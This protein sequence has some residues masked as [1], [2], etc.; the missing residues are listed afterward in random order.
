VQ[1]VES[2]RWQVIPY[3]PAYEVSDRGDVRR[4]T[5][6]SGTHK[7]LV[8]RGSVSR[9]GRRH[10]TLREGGRNVD[11]PVH[12]LVA[13]AFVPGRFP[14]AVVNHIDGNPLNNAATN[15]EWVLPRDNEAHAVRLGLKVYGE[16]IVHA[17]LTADAVREARARYAA[18]GVTVTALAREYGLSI[19]GMSN[20]LRGR[21]WRRVESTAA[22]GFDG[23][24]IVRGAAHR[25]AKVTETEVAEIRRRHAAGESITGLAREYGLNDNSMWKLVHRHTWKHVA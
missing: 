12:R 13:E 18:G 16:G 2:T 9:W 10:V 11:R 1:V 20:A 7:G 21:T 4:V 3:A 14:G 5:P 15:L 6:Q 23:G 24:L 19:N 25:H 17:R 22:S 8:L